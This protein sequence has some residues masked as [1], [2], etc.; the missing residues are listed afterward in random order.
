[1]ENV[2]D[3][4][5]DKQREAA[6]VCDRNVRVV[7]G[8]GSG[9]TRMLMARIVYLIQEIGEDP[10]HIMAITF[11]NKAA[12]EM[13]ERL[14]KMIPDEAGRVWI[15][16][17]HRLCVRIL[18]EDAQSLGY[19]RSF[20]ILDAE[21]QRTLISRFLKDLN[22]DRTEIRPAA[23]TSFISNWKTRGVSP[24]RAASGTY[25]DVIQ[26]AAS[27]V[28]GLY[29]KEKQE[30]RA[31]D[32]D[33]LLV[34]ADRLLKQ[35][36]QVREK[37]QR[38]FDYL[39]VDEFQ[40]IDPL[41]YDIIKNLTRKD[42][43]LCVV[44]DPDQTIYT[45]RGAVMRIL[46]HF[47]QDFTPC[48]TVILDQNYRS[49]PSI[50]DASNAL[51]AR[52]KNRIKKNLF[53]VQKENR[54]IKLFEG[55][56]AEEEARYIAL[57]IRRL[58]QKEKVPSSEIAVLY[59]SNYLSRYLE[60]AMRHYAIPY[61]IFGG[62]RFYERKEVKDVLAY[63]QLLS[64]PDPSD[65]DQRMLDLSLARVINVP[66]RAIGATTM[67]RIQKEAA[68][69]GQSLLR[70][71]E[72]PES[73]KGA[74]VKKLKAFHQLIMDLREEAATLDL[75]DLV[76]LILENTG[77]GEMLEDADE[78]DR[79][80][81]VKEIIADIEAQQREHPDLTL[82]EYLQN[83]ALLSS[84]KEESTDTVSLMT[85]HAAKGTEFDAVFI[86]SLNEDVFPAAK[87]LQEN[88][89]KGLEE[90]RRLMYVAMTRAR[91][92]L[93]LSWNKDKIYGT[94]NYKTVSRF[95]A[96]IPSEYLE[97]ADPSAGSKNSGAGKSSRSLIEKNV[98]SARK[99]GRAV[100]YHPGMLV[101]HSTFGEGVIIN[102][103]GDRLKVA[104]QEPARVQTIKA[105]FA[106]LQI[107]SRES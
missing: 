96:E 32:F 52:N 43:M 89:G 57:E 85:V 54:P 84:T 75:P 17:I 70:T 39:H 101:L 34:E 15:S 11:T 92:Y 40:D 26:E 72:N 29:E 102:V 48:H 88:P 107:L 50:L 61:Q 106:G 73:V 94:W 67:E 16:T 87:A 9:K 51:I 66:R 42:A 14:E 62:I 91:K 31:M 55:S 81:N 44:G 20:T 93:C 53:S 35:D 86:A 100:R 25:E 82:D 63:M 36:Q 38:R 3:Q 41:Q 24:A 1:M 78:E 12:N 47:D 74:A 33:D 19:P 13:R 105:N 97:S 103:D 23:V 59:R 90:E 98:L 65:P 28:Y 18:R 60:T 46:L 99:N 77:Y 6:S 95:L 7:A 71:I 30:L 76:D 27:R 68:S 104:F 80:E 37:W 64:K 4:L 45:W 79:L 58:Q 5:N 83:V 56:T 21:D 22:Y 8:A 49:I 10:S 2:L 69:K